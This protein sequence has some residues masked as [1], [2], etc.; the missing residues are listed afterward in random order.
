MK[1]K[2]MYI[3]LL[4]LKESEGTRCADCASYTE[5]HYLEGEVERS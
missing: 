1:N 3:E 4:S 5:C 2:G